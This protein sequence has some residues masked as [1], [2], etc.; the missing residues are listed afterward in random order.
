MS[1]QNPPGPPAALTAKITI[2]PYI[3]SDGTEL[4]R[5]QMSSSV[6]GEAGGDEYATQAEA[7]A[8]AE[9]FARTLHRKAVAPPD[10]RAVTYTFD[11]TS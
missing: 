9:A 6:F 4:W 2:S 1:P 8:G 5:F 11:P 7:Q 10:S 3:S